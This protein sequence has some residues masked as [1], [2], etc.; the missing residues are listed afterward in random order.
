[1]AFDATRPISVAMAK[2]VLMQTQQQRRFARRG[3]AWLQT[4]ALD[5]FG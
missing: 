5:R 3:S 2:P 1:L 4:G